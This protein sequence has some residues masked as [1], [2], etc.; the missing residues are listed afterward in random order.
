MFSLSKTRSACSWPRLAVLGAFLATAALVCAQSLSYLRDL[1]QL[2]EQHDQAKAAA[3]EPLER[4]YQASLEQLLKRATQGNDLDTAIKIREELE[5]YPGANDARNT[6][7]ELIGY[8]E[9]T[10]PI[11]N[12]HLAREFKPNGKLISTDPPGGKWTING[13]KLI[14]NYNDPSMVDT[15]ELPIKNHQLSGFSKAKHAL[16]L[17][18]IFPK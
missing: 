11:N 14:L 10:D 18:R 15:F 7:L 13:N 1:N 5:K 9:L 2:R 4:R 3:I 8:W 12:A 17:T 16:T 6:P